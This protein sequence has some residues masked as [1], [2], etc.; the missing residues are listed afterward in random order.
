MKKAIL[1]LSL[2]GLANS[3]VAADWVL[4]ALSDDNVNFYIDRDSVEY[5]RTK[6]IG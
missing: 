2:I 3:A 6:K 5:D 4:V 1:L